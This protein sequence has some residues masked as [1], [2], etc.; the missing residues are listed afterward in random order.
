MADE[1][2]EIEVDDAIIRGLAGCLHVIY[3]IFDI[4]VNVF[5]LRGV[6]GEDYGQGP[7]QITPEVIFHPF[8]V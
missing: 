1:C 5:L 2:Y 8:R 4:F 6:V 7:F 3:L